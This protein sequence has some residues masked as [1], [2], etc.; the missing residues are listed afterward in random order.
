M[1]YNSH[2]EYWARSREELIQA[3]ARLGYP[4]EF[5]QLI[6]RQLGSPKAID[7]MAAYL[8]SAEPRSIEE[9]ADEMLA[10]QSEIEIWREKK[11]SEEANT[12][13][14]DILNHGLEYDSWI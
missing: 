2:K 9:I 8:R 11:A 3:L 7:R 13:Y 4:A 14:N 6:A 12:R 10:I 1:T 5:G